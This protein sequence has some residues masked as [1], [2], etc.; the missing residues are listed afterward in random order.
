MVCLFDLRQVL[1]LHQKGKKVTVP[2][3][4]LPQN[5]YNTID[6]NKTCHSVNNR[7]HGCR[8]DKI[9]HEV[10]S[11]VAFSILNDPDISFSE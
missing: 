3:Q 1:S 11:I 10:L 5:G 6:Y 8:L 2:A 9:L 7:L 4:I